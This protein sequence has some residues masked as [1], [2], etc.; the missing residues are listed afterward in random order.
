MIPDLY[1]QVNRYRHII[2]P[3]TG[4]CGLS[5]LS[6]GAQ[7]HRLSQVSSWTTSKWHWVALTHWVAGF[8]KALY[9]TRMAWHVCTWTT[10]VIWFATISTSFH[11]CVGVGIKW[12]FVFMDVLFC[13]GSPR[14]HPPPSGRYGHSQLDT[15]SQSHDPIISFTLLHHTVNSYLCLCYYRLF[16]PSVPLII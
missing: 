14:S 6:D 2:Y 12:F 15:P 5:P 4:W 7:L 16:M 9:I 3:T 1:Y 13:A 10:V 11:Q 8:W